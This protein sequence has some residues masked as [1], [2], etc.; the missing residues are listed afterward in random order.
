M[1]QTPQAHPNL[2]G[3]LSVELWDLPHGMEHHGDK[4]DIHG[5]AL[6]QQRL[7]PTPDLPPGRL[8]QLLVGPVGARKG[9]E[10]IRRRPEDDQQSADLG[11][12][13]W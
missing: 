7:H 9:F 1:E 10:L 6:Q 5:V 11:H 13:C 2:G 4:Q 8:R 12:S 3:E